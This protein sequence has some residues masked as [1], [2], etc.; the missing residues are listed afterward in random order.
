MNKNVARERMSLP[1]DKT[2]LF[3]GAA[4]FNVY[5][6]GF[7][8]LIEAMRIVC[9]MVDNN[10]LL[11]VLAGNGKTDYSSSFECDVKDVGYLSIENLSTMYSAAD[12]FISSSFD[13][14]GPTMVNQSL[15][16]GTPVVAFDTGVAQELVINDE[17][18]YRAKL[19]DTND[20]ALGIIQMI[21]K[22]EYE[23]KE[24]RDNCRN[25]AMEKYSLSVWAK[26]IEEIYNQVVDNTLV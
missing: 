19:K 21:E 5:R 24:I 14:A 16:C 4:N 7:D 18:G 22:N 6:K 8:H 23:K 17:T 10:N 11:L 15:M 9:N 3:A 26:K 1:Q 20:L 25:S 12:L 2:I 13:D